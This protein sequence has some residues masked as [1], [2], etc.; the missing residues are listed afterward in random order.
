MCFGVQYIW[1]IN[2]KHPGSHID[3]TEYLFAV[4]LMRINWGQNL[5]RLEIYVTS[6]CWSSLYGLDSSHLLNTLCNRQFCKSLPRWKTEQVRSVLFSGLVSHD[7]IPNHPHCDLIRS[8]FL[9]DVHTVLNPI[10]KPIGL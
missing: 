6:F 7:K 10:M 4:V 1:S 9:L 2:Y 3:H 5:V 8:Y